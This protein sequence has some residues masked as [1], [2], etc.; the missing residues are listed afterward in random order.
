L[1]LGERLEAVTADEVHAAARTTFNSANRTIGWFE[2][3]A[4]ACR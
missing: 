2:P 1:T 3:M 4:D